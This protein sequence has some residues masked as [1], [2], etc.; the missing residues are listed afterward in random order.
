MGV[1]DLRVLSNADGIDPGRSAEKAEKQSSRCS[2][3]TGRVWHLCGSVR[4]S[5]FDREQRLW[6]LRPYNAEPGSIVPPRGGRRARVEPQV[7]LG[8]IC[9]VATA[10]ISF[11]LDQPPEEVF[12]YI[13]DVRN[14]LR[15]QKDMKRAEKVTEGPVG[16]GTVFETDYRLFG[17]MRLALEDVRRP[18]HLVFVGDGPRMWMRFVLDVAPREAGSSVSFQIDMRPKGVLMWFAPLLR[19][20]LPREMAKRPG[21]FRAALAADGRS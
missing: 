21:Q 3:S 15:W 18:E 1:S 13:A 10:Q 14:E 2:R 7:R 12:D 11:D 5:A 9:A 20:G 17:P 16:D 6:F 4:W 8:R 19:F